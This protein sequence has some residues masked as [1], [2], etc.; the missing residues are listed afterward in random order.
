MDIINSKIVKKLTSFR[1]NEITANKMHLKN[2]A[3]CLEN[4]VM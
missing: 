4:F 2:F 3:C 1:L